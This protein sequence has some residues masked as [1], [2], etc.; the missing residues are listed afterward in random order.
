MPTEK[1]LPSKPN[2]RAQ[3]VK[4]KK[5][6]YYEAFRLLLAN[7]VKAACLANKHPPTELAAVR[8]CLK[9]ECHGRDNANRRINKETE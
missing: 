9:Y 3:C 5:K 2:N 8:R 1:A 7:L 6:G 4:N